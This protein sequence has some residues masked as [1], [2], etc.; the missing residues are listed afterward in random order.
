VDAVIAAHLLLFAQLAAV[1]RN[2]LTARLALG[3]LTRRRTA[4]LDRALF[5]EAAL[6]LKEELDL[7]AGLAGGRFAAAETADGTR[8]A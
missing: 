2:L 4:A 5:G 1:F 7:F 6:A 8:I 3:L